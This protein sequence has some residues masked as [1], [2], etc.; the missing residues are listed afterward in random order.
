[1]KSNLR[2]KYIKGI[3]ALGLALTLSNS[4][5]PLS[6][7]EEQRQEEKLLRFDVNENDYRRIANLSGNKIKE[8]IDHAIYLTNSGQNNIQHDL[9]VT[10]EIL[11][12]LQMLMPQMQLIG[13]LNPLHDELLSG[14]Y[15]QFH[16]D[17]LNVVKKA[18]ELQSYTPEFVTSVKTG[19]DNIE[20]LIKQGETQ[21]S[22]VQQF[23]SFYDDVVKQA[24]Y[25]PI[26]DLEKKLKKIEKTL[27]LNVPDQQ[28][29][30]TL[31]HE[32]KQ[33]LDNCDSLSEKTMIS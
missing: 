13:M 3:F 7:Q 30:L 29:L 25:I 11:N 33:C 22:I 14:D 27:N 5:L 20:S 21:T 28:Q 8:H 24:A 2:K 17:V 15:Y 31:L 6:A 10:K 26:D 19:L 16:Y 12:A 4:Y 23:S 1:M 32:S 18:N 9:Q